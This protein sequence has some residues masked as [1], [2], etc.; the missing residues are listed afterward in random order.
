MTLKG[1]RCKLRFSLKGVL[2]ILK[3]H[4]YVIEKM[5]SSGGIEVLGKNPI[6]NGG[7]SFK[8]NFFYHI[9]FS[10]KNPF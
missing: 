2:I 1:E 9:N 4:N 6:L 8:K 3:N 7:V 10:S 5:E